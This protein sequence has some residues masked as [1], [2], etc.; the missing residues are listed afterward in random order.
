MTARKDYILPLKI[1]KC[2]EMSYET[3]KGHNRSQ[4]HAKSNEATHCHGR[5]KHQ[6]H[7]K[8]HKAIHM[9]TQG[10]TRPNK[11]RKSHTSQ[12][13]Q[14]NTIMCHKSTLFV[15]LHIFCSLAH[16]LFACTFFF[17]CTFF[18]WFVPFFTHV[19]TPTTTRRRT[20]AKLLLGPLSQSLRSKKK[21]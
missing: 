4:C 8:P 5:E 19:S 14:F 13:R 16:F 17:P 20:T 9:T 12:T 6:E 11:A 1:L 10:P 15:P 7:M 21:K 2:H 3:I 18:V